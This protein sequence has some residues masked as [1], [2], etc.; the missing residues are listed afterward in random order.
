M[1]L[2]NP[3][4]LVLTGSKCNGWCYPGGSY[5]DRPIQVPFNGSGWSYVQSLSAIFGFTL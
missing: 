4:Y 2:L 3:I 5:A 1:D